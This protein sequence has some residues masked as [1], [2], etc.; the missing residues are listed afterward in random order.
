MYGAKLKLPCEKAA[1]ADENF[2]DK[3]NEEEHLLLTGG[4]PK[5]I[6]FLLNTP[7]PRIVL[8]VYSILI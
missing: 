8:S 5:I 7:P 1:R 6:W 2:E 4:I 3:S